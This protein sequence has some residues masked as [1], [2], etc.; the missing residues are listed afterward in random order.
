MVVLHHKPA[1]EPGDEPALA[2]LADNVAAT[3]EELKAKGVEFVQPPRKERW[4]EHAIFKD[5]EGNR[6]LF[7]KA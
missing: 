1:H 5:S 6:I 4:G 3:Y 7:A 2:F